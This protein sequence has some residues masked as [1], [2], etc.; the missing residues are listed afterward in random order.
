[1]SLPQQLSFGTLDKIKDRFGLTEIGSP[2]ISLSSPMSPD[3]VGSLRLFSGDSVHKMVYIGLVVPPIGL[4]SH[5]IFAFTKPE[6]HIP[7]FTLDSVMAG[8]YFAFHLDLIPRADLGANLKYMN[9][10]FDN[11]TPIFEE[12]KKI[13]GLTAAQLGPK[14][15]ALMSPWMLAYR[16]SESAFEQIQTPVNG[17]L[18]HWF[19]LV[20]NGIAADAVPA[21]TDFAVRDQ[22]NRDAIFDPEVD[23][24]WAQVSRLIGEETSETLRGILKNQEVENN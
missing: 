22:L 10:V 12:A 8:P 9:A 7:H 20:E 1:M 16:A 5:M 14:Q 19:K 21:S 17:Y 3:P 18:D 24:V 23:K 6:S 11:L 2:Y 15:Y 4:D 13:E